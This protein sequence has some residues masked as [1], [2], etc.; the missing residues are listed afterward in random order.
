MRAA[1]LVLVVCVGACGPSGPPPPFQVVGD[2]FKQTRDRPPPRTSPFFDGKVVRLRAARG[3]TLGVQVVLD[4]TAE[5]A[6]DLAVPGVTVARF[7]VGYLDVKDA[8]T[9]MCGGSTGPGVYPDILFPSDGPV[10][11][12]DAAFFDVAVARDTAPGKLA[13]TLSV[14]ATT[15]PVEL[16]V[17][18]VTIDLDAQTSVWAWYKAAQ[19]AKT[20]HVAE[21]SRELL[22]LEEQYTALFRA[23]GVHLMTDFAANHEFYA[24]RRELLARAPLG[25]VPVKVSQDPAQAAV[26]AKLHL[27]ELA[28]TGL[29]PFA[30]PF[31]E[32]GDDATRAKVRAVSDAMHAAA[33][34][35]RRVL[36]KVTDLP[37]PVYGDSVD[38]YCHPLAFPKIRAGGPAGKRWWAYNGTMPRAGA[39]IIDGPGTNYRV[40]GWL[41]ERYGV[42]LW[43]LWEV[44]YFEDRY[45]KHLGN[46]VMTNPLTFDQRG[47]MKHPDWCNGDGLLAYPEVRPSLR[48]KA[49]RR[50]LQDRALIRKLRECG[51][52]PG[53][54]LH[55]MVPRALADAMDERRPTWSLTE[56]PFEAARAE[57]LDALIARCPK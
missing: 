33:D 14:G 19:V 30:Y 49:L 45:N 55:E 34:G 38:I 57:L 48:L 41:E 1:V 17:E 10:T 36:M 46:D 15:V 52:D 54:L 6:V 51:G 2:S 56:P 9:A 29:T 12:R 42:E 37:S 25:L 44:L 16:T 11:T 32:P 5:L 18:P 40:L 27:A 3:E 23:H 4:H 53:K 35:A 47:F 20:H 13:G 50:G 21:G 26:D 43:F 39:S 22:A 28:G 24:L 8:S 31:D 7:S